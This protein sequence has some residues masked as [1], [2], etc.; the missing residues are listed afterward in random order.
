VIEG[1]FYVLRTGIPW[2][3]LPARFGSPSPVYRC[4]RRWCAAGFFEALWKAG[5]EAYDEASGIAWTWLS[6]GGC[7]AKAPLAQEAVGKNLT[8]RGKKRE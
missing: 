8:G 1:I 6:G 2:N 7:M 5:L 4:F 3:A